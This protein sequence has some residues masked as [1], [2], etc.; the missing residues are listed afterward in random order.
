MVDVIGGITLGDNFTLI[1]VNMW[2]IASAK[3]P[4][5]PYLW[6]LSLYFR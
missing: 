6:S 5:Y 3:A 4:L 2:E 1:F